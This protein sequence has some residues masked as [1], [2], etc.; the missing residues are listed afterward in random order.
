MALHSLTALA[1][2]SAMNLD[3]QHMTFEL[4]HHKKTAPCIAVRTS[5]ISSQKNQAQQPRAH[6]SLDLGL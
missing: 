5:D 6:K 1:M 3:R 2:V 4:Y